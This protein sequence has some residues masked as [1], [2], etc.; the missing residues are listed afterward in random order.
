VATDL[1]AI[2]SRLTSFYDFAGRAVVAVGAGGGQLVE[3]ARPAGR[4]VAVDP[5]RA[6]M[7]RLAARV[8]AIGLTDRF[9]FLQDDILAVRPVGDVVLFEF[10][11][12]LLPDPERALLHAAQ[13]APDVVVIDH[14]QGSQW[15]WCAAEEAG[16]AAAWAAVARRGVRRTLDVGATQRFRDFRELEERLAAQPPASRDRIASLRGQRDIAIDMPYRLALL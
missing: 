9:T 10:C 13:L 11:L 6:A 16:A 8:E 3:Y 5:D 12:H 2:V 15:M 7:E 14:A 1:E 4:V